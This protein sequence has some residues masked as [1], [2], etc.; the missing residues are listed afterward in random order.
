MCTFAS[1][2]ALSFSHQAFT[3]RQLSSTLGPPFQPGHHRLTR[4]P[5]LSPIGQA[6]GV[7]SPGTRG[8][9]GILVSCA[10]IKL[11]KLCLFLCVGAVW[12]CMHFFL[13]TD[14]IGSEF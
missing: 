2:S 14:D 7:E 5:C 9:L 3:S 11:C 4:W 6:G 13:A 12:F 10:A 8:V 1:T